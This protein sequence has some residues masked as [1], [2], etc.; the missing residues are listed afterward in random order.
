MSQNME[1]SGCIRGRGW[2][3]IVAPGLKDLI[4]YLELGQRGMAHLGSYI[5]LWSILKGFPC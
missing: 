2:T 4:V 3:L 5:H 1:G